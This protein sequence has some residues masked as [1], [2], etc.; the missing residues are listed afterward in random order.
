VIR[1]RWTDPKGGD[2]CFL[3]PVEHL[4]FGIETETR[5]LAAQVGVTAEESLKHHV[6][7]FQGP[8]GWLW[9]VDVLGEVPETRLAEVVAFEPRGPRASRGHVLVP[10]A[11]S[12]P[13]AADLVGRCLP[14]SSRFQVVSAHEVEELRRV[15]GF[16]QEGGAA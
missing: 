6:P 10:A 3:L 5:T 16:N 2:A 9:Q 7:Y 4:R 13:A 14:R 1:V 8:D 12:D 15:F 11:I